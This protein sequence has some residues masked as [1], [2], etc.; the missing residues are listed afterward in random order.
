MLSRESKVK[1]LMANEQVLAIL[2]DQLP[3]LVSNKQ[4]KL[5]NNMPFTKVLGMITPD[6]C[7]DE[8]KESIC[9]AIEGLQAE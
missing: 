2:T 9:I 6:K 1:D 7:S 4:L 5:L 3:S 8:K